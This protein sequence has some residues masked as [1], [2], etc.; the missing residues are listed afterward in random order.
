MLKTLLHQHMKN[1]I[2]IINT[3]VHIKCKAKYNLF[4]IVISMFS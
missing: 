2:N 4:F 3:E 1:V